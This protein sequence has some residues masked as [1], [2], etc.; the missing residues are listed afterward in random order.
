MKNLKIILG[1][2]TAVLL[3]QSCK[4]ETLTAYTLDAGIS[5]YKVGME[6]GQDSLIRSFAILPETTLA[7]TVTIPL[8]ILGQPA[9]HDRQVQF[10]V[11]LTN[12]T[13]TAD[14]YELLP[15]FIPAGEFVG[16]LRV[17][18]NKTQALK[19]QEAKIWVELL[20][21]ADFNVGPKELASYVI[22]VNDYL[23]KPASWQDVRFGEYSQ[24]KYGLIIRETGYAVFTGL[25]PEVFFYI[26]SKSRN[27]LLAYQATHGKELL[28]EHQIPVSFP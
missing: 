16:E 19:T 20:S 21:S 3:I 7:D 6:E 1:L 14:Q 22:K 24:V 8:R 27:A 17:K 5:M 10:A 9:Q 28:D 26:V 4:K 2:M 15:S 23:S 13:A 25:H 11:N 18:L 12:S